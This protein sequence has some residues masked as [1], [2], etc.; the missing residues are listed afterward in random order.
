MYRNDSLFILE[1]EIMRFIY[2]ITIIN[3]NHRIKNTKTKKT[4]FVN[5]KLIIL[6]KLLFLIA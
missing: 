4:F 6:N 2:R 1:A 5:T 3:A